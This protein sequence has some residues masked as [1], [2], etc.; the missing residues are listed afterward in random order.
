MIEQSILNKNIVVLNKFD[1]L[2]SKYFKKYFTLWQKHFFT[3][4]QLSF[5]TFNWRQKSLHGLTLENLYGGKLV[6]KAQLH[7]GLLLESVTLLVG[8]IKAAVHGEYELILLTQSVPRELIQFYISFLCL[9]LYGGLG[10]EEGFLLL[11]L[12]L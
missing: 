7:T 6:A 5:I 10:T 12:A 8:V 9:Q 1:I 2:F 11:N 3:T 4:N